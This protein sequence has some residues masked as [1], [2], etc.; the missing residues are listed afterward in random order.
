MV[1]CLRA[2]IVLSET[3]SSVPTSHLQPP[4]IP[5]PGE[6][7]PYGLRGYLHSCAHTARPQP[8]HTHNQK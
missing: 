8:M 7:D 2:C 3:W 5:A 1:H 4:I 6:S